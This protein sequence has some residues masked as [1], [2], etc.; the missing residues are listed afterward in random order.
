MVVALLGAAAVATAVA[1]GAEPVDPGADP[2]GDARG[3]GR[4]RGATSTRSCPCDP[5]RAGRAGRRL[6]RDGPP[7]PRVP[8]GRDRPAAAGAADGAGDDRLVPRPGGGRRPG[9][10]RRA[11]Q[12]GGPP[13]PRRG[14][15]RTARS[16]GPRRRRCGPRWPRSSAAGPT[17]CRRAWST[18][19]ASATTARSGSTCPA[20]WR[21]AATDGL[22]GAAVVLQDVTKFRLVD[23]LK[24]DMV[25]TVSHELKTPL[26]SIQM[27]VHLLLEEVVGPLTPKQVELLLAARQDSDRLLAMVND[28]LDLTRIEQG[29]VAARPAH[30]RAGRPG[31][32]GRRAVRGQGPGRGRRAARSAWRP[33]CRRSWSTASGSRTSS[34][35]WSATPWRTPAA[36]ARSASRPSPTGT[37]VRFAVAD[38]GEGIAAEHLPRLFEKFYRVPGSRS[39]GR[40]RARP[41]HRPRDR[42]GPRRPD[43]R[44]Q[45]PGRGDDLHLHP[46]D[47]P[48]WRRPAHPR[49]ADAMSRRQAHPDRRRRA[50]RPARLPHGPGVGRL[51]DLRRRRTGRRPCEVLERAPADLVLLDLHMPGLGGMEVAP[52]P[53]RRGQR[54]AGRHR[55][56]ARQRA[57]RRRRR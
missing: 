19:S 28:L 24:S 3:A 2:R 55:H 49:G 27:A 10:R 52:T 13:H 4:W 39:A 6:Q 51:R 1:A 23:Q 36:G 9:R 25:S 34:T 46:A 30:R 15:R 41:G 8:A 42:R 54:R 22:L 57:Q 44:G 32:R 14:A 48:R 21:S 20:S 26:T 56:G 17:T 31:R 35:T 7:H 5:R 38:T 16:P 40:C 47:R 43:R 53:P 18:P 33:A 45:P 29:R 37:S 50:Q 11:G 12:P